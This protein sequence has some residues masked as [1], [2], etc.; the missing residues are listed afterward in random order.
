MRTRSRSFRDTLLILGIA[1]TAGPLLLFGSVMWHN[2]QQLQEIAYAGCLH[3]A[4]ADLDHIAEG[5]Y[6]LCD[7]SRT[8]LA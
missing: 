1:L 6:R 3:G 7:D 4:E 8:A 2:H 5:V